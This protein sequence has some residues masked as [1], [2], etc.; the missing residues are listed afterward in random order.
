MTIHSSITQERVL[1]L[2]QADDGSGICLAC[3]EDASGCEPDARNY[4][5]ESCG[6]RKVYGAEEIL[7]MVTR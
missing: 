4:P 2:A 1:D 5:C 7:I 6:A 3:G